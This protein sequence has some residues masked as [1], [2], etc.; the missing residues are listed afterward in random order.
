MAF[1]FRVLEHVIS[2]QH[3]REHPH[4]LKENQE[5]ALKIA[6]KQYIPLDQTQPVSENAVTIIGTQGNGFPKSFEETYEPLW[7]DMFLYLKQRGI[8]VRGIWMADA[9]NQGASGVLNEHVQGDMSKRFYVLVG[10]WY[11]LSVIANWFDHS[12][13]LLHMVNHFRSE[14]RR[15][16]IGIGHSMGCAE[17]SVLLAYG[18]RASL[19]AGRIEL[20]IIHPRLLSTIILYEP[21]VLQTL[22]KG[23]NP[24][25]MATSRRDLWPS[26]EKA[27][28]ALRKGFANFDPRAIDRYLQYGLRA[29]PTRL[30]DPG[31][32]PSIPATAVTLT[33]SKHQEAWTLA[34]PNLE[35]KS[36]GLDDL[37]LFDW[38]PAIERSLA[39]SRPEPWAAMRNLPHVR[40]SVLCVYGARS[41]LSQPEAQDLRLSMTG[42]GVGGSGGLSRGMVDKAV[43]P[44]GTHLVVFEDV[45][46]CAQVAADWIGRWSQRYLQEEKFWR[47]YRSKKSDADMLRSSE[48]ALAVAKLMLGASRKEIITSKL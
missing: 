30:Y 11:L 5:A 18:R 47:S 35:P 34:V 6:I 16:I 7:Q 10:W 29:V 31:N 15:P 44:Q 36:A 40:P 24:A 46:W 25:I 1:P 42:K 19:M 4:A 17:M 9:T 22:M 12:R 45:D 20:S 8:P 41:S 2:G 33:T 21:V 27:E 26:R 38:D 23:P 13:D 43:S 37:L 48:A 39:S 3:I 14:I 28:S 32:D